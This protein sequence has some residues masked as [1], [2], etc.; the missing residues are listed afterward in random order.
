MIINSNKSTKPTKSYQIQTQKTNMIIKVFTPILTITWGI[1]ISLK[2]INRIIPIHI[3]NH[4]MI[5]KNK[6]KILNL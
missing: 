3:I 6:D 1:S 5:F 2:K 4:N